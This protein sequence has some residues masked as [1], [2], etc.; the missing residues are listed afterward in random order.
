MII[1][2]L[3]LEALKDI[4]LYLLKYKEDENPTTIKKSGGFMARL[5]EAMEKQEKLK[6]K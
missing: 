3:Y 4:N 5:D 1:R 2:Y 6:N